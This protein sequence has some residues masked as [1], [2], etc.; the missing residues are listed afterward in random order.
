MGPAAG[1]GCE[2]NACAAT[3]GASRGGV[4]RGGSGLGVEQRA[5]HLVGGL[6]HGGIHLV[7]ALALDLADDVAGIEI[8]LCDGLGGGAEAREP[9]PHAF[10]GGGDGTGQAG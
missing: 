4:P 2:V 5:E 9:T 10:L 8:A 7:G 1:T 6:E 3:R